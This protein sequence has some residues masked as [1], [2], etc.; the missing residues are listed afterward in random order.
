[1]S[2]ELLTRFS[3]GSMNNEKYKDLWVKGASLFI[4]QL[5]T[6]LKY[7]DYKPNIID[8]SKYNNS[9][10]NILADVLN[11]YN[12]DKARHHNYNILYSY[13]LNK[14]GRFD[15]LNI[16]EIGLGTNNPTLVSSMGTDGK[17]GASLYTWQEYLPNSN[18]YGA[19]IDKDILFNKDRIKTHYVDQLDMS[20]FNTMQESFKTKYDMIIDDGL[21]SIGANLNT[22]LFALENVNDDGW[23]VIEDIATQYMDNWFSIDYLLKQNSNYE[24]SI[25]KARHSYMFVVHKLKKHI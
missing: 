7:T 13:I 14:L 11:K 12:S 10:A 9:D 3:A 18:I 20:T 17:P 8:I 6:F 23:I 21:H 4:D 24:V 5:N 22:L 19:D 15:K 25:I 1:M 16:L 2:I